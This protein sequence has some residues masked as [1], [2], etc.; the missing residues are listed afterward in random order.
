VTYAE[1]AVDG[2]D[3]ATAS[4]GTKAVGVKAEAEA[5]KAAKAVNLIFVTVFC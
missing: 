5:R 1:T 4:L 3:E 2:L